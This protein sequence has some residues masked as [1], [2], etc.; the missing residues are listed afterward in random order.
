MYATS[1]AITIKIS[2]HNLNFKNFWGG[3]WIST[4][5]YDLGSDS[6]SGTIRVHCHYFE[7]GN[8]QFELTKS[9]DNIAVKNSTGKGIVDAICKEETKVRQKQ[10]VILTLF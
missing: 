9:L 4:W 1:A 6:L 8:I 7:Q 3:E 10:K 2:C 5:V